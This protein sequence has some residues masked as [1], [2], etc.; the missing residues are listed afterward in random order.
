MLGAMA[1]RG[2]ATMAAMASGG[3]GAVSSSVM[4]G[5]DHYHPM[6]DVFIPVRLG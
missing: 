6:V 1:V 2:M 4:I 3:G 5:S